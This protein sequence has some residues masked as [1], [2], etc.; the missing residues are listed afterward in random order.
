ML[1]NFTNM[2]TKARIVIVDDNQ[3]VREAM[4]TLLSAFGHRV[5]E[6]ADSPANASKLIEQMQQGKPE[7]VD[8]LLV[9]GN[10]TPRAHGNVEGSAV[11]LEASQRCPGVTIIGTP[12]S[13]TISSAHLSIPK[14]ERDAVL[15]AI[16]AAPRNETVYP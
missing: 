13:G 3:D 1:Y 4:K 14:G 10:L 9:D 8:V 5:V 16:Q 12:G 15:K 6:T 2:P 7:P 11:A